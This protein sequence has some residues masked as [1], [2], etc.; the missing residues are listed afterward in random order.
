M[1]VDITVICKYSR[2]IK[3]NKY[4]IILELIFKESN[5]KY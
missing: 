1:E 2:L 3:F 4:K 5:N